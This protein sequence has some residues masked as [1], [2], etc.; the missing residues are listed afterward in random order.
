LQVLAEK[1]VVGQLR[2]RGHE[3]VRMPRAQRLGPVGPRPFVEAGVQ[4]PEKRV[5]VE[6]P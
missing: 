6:P 3:S 4:R 2:A 1:D 5:V